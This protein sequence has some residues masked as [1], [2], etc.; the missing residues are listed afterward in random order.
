M[1]ISDWSS[2]VCSSD[3]ARLVTPHHDHDNAPASDAV[4]SGADC[5]TEAAGLSL[6]WRTPI[7]LNF[8]A[9]IRSLVEDGEASAARLASALWTLALSAS[10]HPPETAARASG[11]RAFV[12]LPPGEPAPARL[13]PH[14]LGRAHV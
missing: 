7:D 10:G 1:R 12:R 9:A 13:A 11:V 3:L 2:D 14:A 8:N 6:L 4:H 5:R